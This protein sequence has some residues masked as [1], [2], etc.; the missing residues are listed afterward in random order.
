[1]QIHWPTTSTNRKILDR[2]NR[3]VSLKLIRSLVE[4]KMKERSNRFHYALCM[5]ACQEFKGQR[6]KMFFYH[7]KNMSFYVPLLFFTNKVS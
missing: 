5:M 1:M 4:E 6:S 3:S 7:I 2:K